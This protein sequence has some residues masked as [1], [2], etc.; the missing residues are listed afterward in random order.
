MYDLTM[1]IDGQEYLLKVPMLQHLTAFSPKNTIRYSWAAETMVQRFFG[2][3]ILYWP[4]YSLG[5][6]ASILRQHS[7]QPSV[8]YINPQTY[9][10][11]LGQ[12]GATMENTGITTQTGNYGGLASWLPDV[13]EK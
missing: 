4:S 11:T 12:L 3:S 10:Q 7:S 9:Q 13:G 2:A 1:K 8:T 6:M 5:T